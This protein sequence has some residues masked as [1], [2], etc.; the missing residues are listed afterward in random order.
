MTKP[1]GKIIYPTGKGTNLIG[2]GAEPMEN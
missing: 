1:I 2:K